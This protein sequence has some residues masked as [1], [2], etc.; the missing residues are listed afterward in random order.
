MIEQPAGRRDDDVGAALEGGGLLAEADAAVDGRDFDV[1]VLRERREVRGDL[2]CEFARRRQDQGLRLPARAVHQHLHERQTEGGRFAAAG[3]GA[4]QQIAAAQCGRDRGTLHRGGFGEPEL[5]N[6]TEKLRSQPKA[7]EGRDD[8]SSFRV[9]RNRSAKENERS[10]GDGLSS[11]IRGFS[12]TVG[13]EN[14]TL[15]RR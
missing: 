5:R 14:E 7:I 3:G 1:G 13:S 6:G 4:G 15:G 8:R 12:S 9:V 11:H 2:R 10:R